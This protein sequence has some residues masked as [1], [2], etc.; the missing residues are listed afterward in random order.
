[1]KDDQNIFRGCR[2]QQDYGEFGTFVHETAEKIH[3]KYRR[4][5]GVC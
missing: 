2:N 5:E 4:I 3:P 1:M